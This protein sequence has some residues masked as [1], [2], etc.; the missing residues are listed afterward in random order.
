[1]SAL[2]VATAQRE[3]SMPV[4][5]VC[6]G[7]GRALEWHKPCPCP[8]RSRLESWQGLPRTL[9][10]QKYWGECDQQT[11]SAVLDLMET[12]PWRQALKQV[13]GDQPV[14]HHLTSEIGPDFVHAMPWD[15]IG[16]VLDVGAGMGF[17]TVPLARY[18]KR[19]VAVEAVPERALFLVRRAAQE[20]LD[21]IHPLIA[22]AMALPFSAESFDLITL[23][24]VFEYIGL[25][26]AG[27]PQHAQER[28]LRRAYDLLRPGG[29]LYIGI[30]TRY[31]LGAWLGGRDHSGLRFTSLMPRRVA[32]WYC[33]R[34]RV[35][36]YGSQVATAG[37][38]T[39][40]HTP[41][42]Y[43]RMLRAAGFETVEVH[44]CFDGYNRQIGVYP[45]NDF[46]ARH[47]TRR[48]IDVAG[49]WPGAVRRWIANSRLFYRMLEGDVILFARKERQQS[50]LAWSFLPASGTVT[51]ISTGG[52]VFAIA[53]DTGR[54]MTVTKSGKHRV[55]DEGLQ[56]EYDFLQKLDKDYGTQTASWPMRWPWPLGTSRGHGRTAFRY[57]FIDGFALSTMLLPRHYRPRRFQRFLTRLIESYL[58]LCE[59]LTPPSTP[60][61]DAAARERLAE[62]LADVEVTDPA[63]RGRIQAACGRLPRR[64]WKPLVVHGDLIINNIIVQADERMVLVDWENAAS[65]G[66]PALDLLRLLYD[67]ASDSYLLKPA[68]RATLL[69]R[70]K[71]IIR[72]ALDRLGLGFDD[73][74]DLEALFIAHQW[75]LS[76]LRH[77]SDFDRLLD[78]ARNQ[79]F[80]LKP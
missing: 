49:S 4:A 63:V 37:Y 3:A 28:F 32:D 27:N 33:R 24:G 43:E 2:A 73:Y 39:Y 51:Q 70:S 74:D 21:N 14:Y 53:F 34:R 1:M 47:V 45:L 12:T 52:K 36:F 54:P 11:M 20:D 46:R 19:V 68:A 29:Y 22:S 55:S 31:A 59:R 7:C 26:D 38:R 57:E 75:Q 58:A 76:T 71:R 62:A 10:E 60:R 5:L 50:R 23:N 78:G 25:W 61:R 18:A 40:T 79:T 9:F 48:M 35:P 13:A 65:S 80:A 15:R 77:G 16:T 56:R 44:G 69:A 64:P 67:I 8:A 6:P 72:A 42:Q 30:E 41:N 17:M 66:L